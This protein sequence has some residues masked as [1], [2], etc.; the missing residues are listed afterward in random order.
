MTLAVNLAQGASNN[1]TFRNRI[2]NGACVIDQRNAGASVTAT[3]V[4]GVNY[5]LDRFGYSASQASKFTV[6]QNAGSVTPPAGFTYYLGVTS[7]SAYSVVSGDYFG[8]RQRIEGFNVADLAWGTASASPVTLS[9]WVR[10]SLTGTFA[11]SLANSAENRSYPFSYTISSANTWEQKSIT[12]AGD[13]TGTWLTTS[14]IGIQLNFSLG[15]GST[16]SGTAGAW[17]GSTLLSATG[18]VSVVGTSGATFYITGVQ[19]EAGT[20][21]SPFEYRQ[22]GTELALCQ[23]YFETSF[24]YGTAVGTATNVGCVSGN[25]LQGITTTTE[26]NIYV[27]FQVAKRAEPTMSVWDTNGNASKVNRVTC[28]VTD[29]QNQPYG[30]V[31]NSGTTGV[32]LYSGSG[33][34]CGAI[35]IQFTASSEL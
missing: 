30:G 32:V 27:K 18:A 23:R 29:N 24:V 33:S 5:V 35:K 14:G 20:T 15:T 7:S 13:T 4:G 2:I 8:I 12:I 34:A 19:L 26:A 3:A 11:G 16:Y 25:G 28:G 22:Y 21:A 6:Q 1:V 10:S 9:F 17:A 31:A